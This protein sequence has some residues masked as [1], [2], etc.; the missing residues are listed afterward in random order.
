M[1]TH[2]LPIECP[3]HY[4]INNTDYLEEHLAINEI[5]Q[6]HLNA[7]FTFWSNLE[8]SM[9]LHA[10][11]LDT[12]SRLNYGI[13]LIQRFYHYH[14]ITMHDGLSFGLAY[15]HAIDKV[16][17]THKDFEDFHYIAYF[18]AIIKGYEKGSRQIFRCLRETETLEL[19]NKKRMNKSLSKSLISK[20]QDYVN[21]ILNFEISNVN[22]N[23][24]K[25]KQLAYDII[26]I[27]NPAQMIREEILQSFGLGQKI[28][29][30]YDKVPVFEND[31]YPDGKKF[32]YD[33]FKPNNIPYGNEMRNLPIY[34]ELMAKGVVAQKNAVMALIIKMIYGEKYGDFEYKQV[35][36]CNLLLRK[37]LPFDLEEMITILKAITKGYVNHYFG[38]LSFFKNVDTYLKKYPLTKELEEALQAVLSIKEEYP[39]KSF[40][41]FQVKIDE[42]LSIKNNTTT[43]IKPVLLDN[44]DKF[45]QLVNHQIS[46]L[47][48]EEAQHWYSLFTICKKATTGKPS[49]KFQKE[50][51]KAVETIDAQFY[52][53]KMNEWLDFLRTMDM[54]SDGYY[55]HYLLR[56]TNQDTV[57]GLIWTLSPLL[58][59]VIMPKLHQFTL[60]CYEK[61]SGVGPRATAVG[62]ACIFAFANGGS[63][64]SINYLTRIKTKVRNKTIL[65]VIEKYI[66]IA[67]EELGVTADMLEDMAVQE[68]DLTDGRVLYKF[69]DYGLEINI[70]RIGKVSMQWYKPD[71]KTQKSVPAF[72]KKTQA[73][74]LKSI[75][76][77]VKNISQNLTAQRNRLDRCYIQDRTW[78]YS[79]FKK[80]YLEHGL[81]S[82][83]AKRL[84]WI[85]EKGEEKATAFWRDGWK[86]TNGVAINWIN[87]ETTVKLWHP[88]FSDI[89]EIQAWRDFMQKYEIV[90]PMKQAFREVYL[91]TDAEINTKTYSNRMAAHILKQHQFNQLAKLRGWSY[92]LIGGWDGGYD[93]HCTIEIPA[94]D[95]QAEY[96]I[97]HLPNDEHYTDS[98][99]YIYVGTDQVRFYN[100]Q[101]NN[102]LSMIDI[103]KIIF[104]EIMRDVDMF[105]G[106]SSV[107]ND[108][109]WNDNGG[110]P[111]HRDYWASYSFGDLT[112]V[113]KTRKSILERLLPK[114]KIAKVAELDGKFLKVK[115]TYTTYKIHIGSTNILM[116]PN[117]Q[118]LC[119]VPSGK[120]DKNT[121]SIF[122]PFE[123]DRGFSILLSKAFM[124]ADDTKITDSTIISQ[125]PI[126]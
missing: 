95:L 83:L 60:R 126:R 21:T 53:H 45:G 121:E 125:L 116:E 18:D 30:Y 68:Y 31:V 98:G 84:V 8:K 85:F 49:K 111:Q 122:L 37:K 56:P 65:N 54:T 86:T 28:V 17:S 48:P 109:Q 52:V 74:R 72:V 32:V 104:S 80:Y 89:P 75:K 119:I 33:F 82:F 77:Q 61:I 44:G 62:N 12:K 38:Y 110:M 97:T 39:S 102:P 13:A 78:T 73:A 25:R 1:A 19:L 6:Q 34:Q 107:G 27:N 91:L 4:I 103:P 69:E 100:Q 118:Y 106:V 50:T 101:R 16:F 23:N 47:A 93:E 51:Q 124:L 15:E 117:D 10:K 46:L 24:T 90:Q 20:V 43:E 123:G 9:V 2:E 42:H 94:F 87:N 71:G 66:K 112:E 115:G 55:S 63:L 58:D 5:I 36:L 79:D 92:T 35:E 108:P 11:S 40:T 3:D 57:K 88:V 41:K 70:E 64:E 59:P 76:T 113:A 105:V 29:K 22:D 120:K 96:W 14:N 99:I 81:M 114:L 26:G 7:D 67:S